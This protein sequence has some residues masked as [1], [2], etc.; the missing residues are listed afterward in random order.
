[1][2]IKDKSYGVV[3]VHKGDTD[4][5]L[6]LRQVD[7]HWSFP[8]GHKE[9][10]ENGIDAAKRELL[11]EAG[12]SDADFADLPPLYEQYTFSDSRGITYDK[13]VKYFIAFA[14][15]DIVKIQESEISEYKWA[16]YEEALDTFNFPGVKDVLKNVN[17]Y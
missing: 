7:G 5:F 9:G 4:R 16:T 14:K 12:V 11:E 17:E 15:D 13:T 10:E 6:I 3:L 8:K 2:A 1:M